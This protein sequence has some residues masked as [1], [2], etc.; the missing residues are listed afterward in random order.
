MSEMP[1]FACYYN[2]L[3][4]LHK[5]F[6]EVVRVLSLIHSL[7]TKMRPTIF[8]SAPQCEY[9]H[10]PH[11]ELQVARCKLQQIQPQTLNLTFTWL[12][13]RPARPARPTSNFDSLSG[14]QLPRAI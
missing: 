7:L 11:T 8:L 10:L 13:S 1:A 4:S 5:Q 12:Q 6:D 9:E 2:T 3:L 14:C